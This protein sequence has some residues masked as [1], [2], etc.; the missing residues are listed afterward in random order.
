M[1]DGLASRW[2]SQFF[3]TLCEDRSVAQELRDASTQSDLARWT[4]SLTGVVVKC[5]A[6][7]GM[8]AAAKGHP[9]TVRAVKQQ[10]Y[11]GQD[12]MAFA[13]G[14]SGWSLPAAVCELEN[15]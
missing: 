11:L 8:N 14:S 12:V 6:A 2:A 7:I 9:G 4:A 15:A 3:A 13:A 1:S 10:E 5:F